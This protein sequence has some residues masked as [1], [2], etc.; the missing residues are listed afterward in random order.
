[1]IFEVG[2]F[3]SHEAGRQIAVLS[4]V[5]TYKWRKMLVIEEADGTGHSISCA[6]IGEANDHNWVEIGKEEWM[7]N[8]R[9]IQ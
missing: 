9:R 5:E 2:K 6:E 7:Q 1:M 4:E 8:F 3:Y